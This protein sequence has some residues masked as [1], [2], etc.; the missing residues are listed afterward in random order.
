MSGSICRIACRIR[1]VNHKPKDKFIMRIQKEF[2]SEDA[3]AS[4][5]IKEKKHLIAD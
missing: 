2:L 1:I 5:L 3:S 4:E